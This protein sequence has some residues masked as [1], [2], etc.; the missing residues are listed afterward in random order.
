[1]ISHN[2]INIKIH[3]QSK[4]KKGLNLNNA[5]NQAL[6][7]VCVYLSVIIKKNGVKKII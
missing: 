4:K 3:Q 6:Q 7:Q 1:M 2:S 5:R